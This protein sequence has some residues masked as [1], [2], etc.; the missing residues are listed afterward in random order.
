[1]PAFKEF[2]KTTIIGGVL[3]LAP[4]I[5]FALILR[6]AMGFAGK[7][8]KPIAAQFPQHQIA[9]VAVA[10]IVAALV[11]LV[12]SFCAGLAARTRAGKSATHWLEETLLGNL[13]QYRMVKSLAEGLTQVEGVQGMHPALVSI[14]G[15]WQL[16]YQLEELKEGWVAV[17]LPQSPTPMSGNVM[18]LPATRVR[19]LEIPIPEAMML[20]KRM[21]VGSAA[22]LSSVDLTPVAEG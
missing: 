1:M 3:F 2:L 11:L 15:G 16:G 7:F 5:L 19:L 21:G 18:Y 10:T 22:T 9:G 4:V 17:F 13:P 6:H 8:A 12:L 20:V 14:E